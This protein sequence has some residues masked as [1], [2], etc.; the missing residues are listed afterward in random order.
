MPGVSTGEYPSEY[1]GLFPA[2]NTLT[3]T[4]ENLISAPLKMNTEAWNG[5][6]SGVG[7]VGCSIHSGSGT[8]QGNLAAG[9]G[10]DLLPHRRSRRRPL[11]DL[12]V[13]RLGRDRFRDHLGR[14]RLA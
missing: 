8:P 1:L 10:S 12:R 14:H 7:V 2:T 13:H 4:Q 3:S 11:N 9:Q 5:A 6:N